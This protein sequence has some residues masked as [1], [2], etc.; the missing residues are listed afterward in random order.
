MVI[1]PDKL[2]KFTIRPNASVD[3]AIQKIELNRYGTLVVVG[4]DAKVLGTLTDGDIRKSL[5]SHRLMIIPVAEVMHANFLAVDEGTID[6]ARELFRDRFY[7]RLLP[8]VDSI[9]RLVDII[10]R[11]EIT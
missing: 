6:K 11:N 2:A 8:V 9:G 10:L 7:L 1:D 4:N 3:E 5:L